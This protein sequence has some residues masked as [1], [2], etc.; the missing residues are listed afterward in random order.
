MNLGNDKSKERERDVDIAARIKAFLSGVDLYPPPKIL[1]EPVPDKTVIEAGQ[2]W[3]TGP[4]PEF[5]EGLPGDCVSD[6]PFLVLVLDADHE[7]VEGH[8]ILTVA[9]ILPEAEMAGP[10]DLLLPASVLG[11]E[12]VVAV[13]YAVGMLEDNLAE[14]Q[15][16]IPQQWR[17]RVARFRQWVQGITPTAPTDVRTGRNYLDEI[18]LRYQ[19]HERLVDQLGYLQAPYI[20]WLERCGVLA[21]DKAPEASTAFERISEWWAQLSE[22]VRSGFSRVIDPLIRLP[23]EAG[24]AG[25]QWSRAMVYKGELDTLVRELTRGELKDGPRRTEPATA[26]VHTG[27]ADDPDRPG[28]CLA[29]WEITQTA[30][31]LR[32]GELFHVY[33]L[34]DHRIIGAGHLSANGRFAILTEGSWADFAVPARDT[35]RLVL[36]IQE[37]SNGRKSE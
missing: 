12:A 11:Y 7:P 18:D 6:D 20:T 17:D 37:A 9:P 4:E 36:L 30:A 19:F 21:W 22:S 2:V 3:G 26:R 14:C 5:P 23:A 27:I 33:D 15:G 32:G 16:S 34:Q 13:A 1:L 29:R 10:S 35:G 28:M 31:S 8:R 24:Q 25:E